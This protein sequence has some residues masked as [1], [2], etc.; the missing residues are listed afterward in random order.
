MHGILDV[1]HQDQFFFL[2][3]NFVKESQIFRFLMFLYY[4]SYIFSGILLYKKAATHTINFSLIFFFLSL[5][6]VS[7]PACAYL[8]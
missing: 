3:A 8:D 7:G 4:F 6:W 2:V 1:S 5:T